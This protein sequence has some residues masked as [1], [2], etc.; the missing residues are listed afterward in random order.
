MKLNEND[1]ENIIKMIVNDGEVIDGTMEYRKDGEV[2][3]FIYTLMIDG[4]YESGT[5]AYICES[6]DFE[7]DDD[8]IECFNADGD[9]VEHDFDVNKVVIGTFK[10]SD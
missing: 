2:L 10:F 4:F 8:S 6:V 7:I 1:Y 3:S 5:H 9:D